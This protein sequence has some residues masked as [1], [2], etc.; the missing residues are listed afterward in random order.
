MN[1]YWT[2]QEKGLD[3]GRLIFPYFRKQ[4][5]AVSDAAQCY[6]RRQTWSLLSMTHSLG[7]GFQFSVPQQHSLATNHK[8]TL[9]AFWEMIGTGSSDDKLACKMSL[10][11]F[12]KGGKTLWLVWIS[13]MRVHGPGSGCE[14]LGKFFCRHTVALWESAVFQGNEKLLVKQLGILHNTFYKSCSISITPYAAA[15]AGI[16]VTQMTDFNPLLSCSFDVDSSWLPLLRLVI[17]ESPR[18]DCD[19]CLCFLQGICLLYCKPR[20]THS[21]TD[22]KNMGRN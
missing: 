1:F 7:L 8:V 4:L 9:A 18:R 3:T 11:S 20:T 15:A 5:L 2:K 19:R 12:I 10:K 6:I 16:H 17:G 13:L 14:G 22:R 21:L